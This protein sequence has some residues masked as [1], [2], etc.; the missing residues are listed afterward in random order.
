MGI[1]GDMLREGESLFKNEDALDG[2][3]IPRNLPYRENQHHH[4]ASVIKP[5]L[6]GRNG[7]N[8]FI[9]G[10]PGIGKTAAVKWVLRELEE[11]TNITQNDIELHPFVDF[12]WHPLDM[13]MKVY[14]GKLQHEVT[15]ID[16][17]HKLYWIDVHENF[18]DTSRFAGE[19]NIAHMMA[20]YF[21]LKDQLFN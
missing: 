18:F 14:I 21:D 10:A 6:M 17:A 9:C 16:E 20:F 13:E 19:G 15:L 1:F 2:D 11:E 12:V 7:R 5:L 4:V 3:F 8:L